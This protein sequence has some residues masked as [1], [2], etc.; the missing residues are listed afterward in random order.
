MFI[1][2]MVIHKLKVPPSYIQ[3]GIVFEALSSIL[4]IDLGVVI[5]RNTS[6]VSVSLLIFQITENDNSMIK[7]SRIFMISY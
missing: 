7:Y 1:E 4:V 2:K 3:N 5:G 6:L